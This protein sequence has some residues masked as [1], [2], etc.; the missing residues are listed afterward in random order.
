MLGGRRHDATVS[1]VAKTVD[2]NA[3]AEPG[4]GPTHRV[5]W[6]A[7]ARARNH[8][9]ERWPPRVLRVQPWCVERA[10]SFRSA[11]HVERRMWSAAE[12]Y[13]AVEHLAC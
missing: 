6:F 8:R 2:A 13:G 5:R 3:N 7:C 12:P 1:T 11:A 10:A 9:A 4:P